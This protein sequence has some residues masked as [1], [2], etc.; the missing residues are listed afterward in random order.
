M[1]A[2]SHTAH[3]GRVVGAN[4]ETLDEVVALVFREPNSYTGE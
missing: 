3:F 4:G 1:N 2:K